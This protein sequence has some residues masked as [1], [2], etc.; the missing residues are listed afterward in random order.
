[1]K[2]KIDYAYLA[3]LLLMFG[4]GVLIGFMFWGL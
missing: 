2:G 1:M 3:S 4:V